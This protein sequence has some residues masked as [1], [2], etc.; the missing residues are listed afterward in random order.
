MP[1]TDR[2]ERLIAIMLGRLEMDVEECIATYSNFAEAVFGERLSSIP[3]NFKGGVK[4]RFDSA[5][6]ES[7]I[8][9]IVKKSGV[10]EAELFNNG[11]EHGCKT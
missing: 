5:K 4:S 6:L 10:P 9:G 1:R 8:Q 7:A 11:K 2:Q 3:F